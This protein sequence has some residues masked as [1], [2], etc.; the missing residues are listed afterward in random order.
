MKACKEI[1]VFGVRVFLVLSG[2]ASVPPVTQL[3]WSQ[4]VLGRDLQFDGTSTN[5]RL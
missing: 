1:A 2:C 4:G 5:M 3:S